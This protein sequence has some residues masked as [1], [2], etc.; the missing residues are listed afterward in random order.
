MKPWK[1]VQSEH[2]VFLLLSFGE[3]DWKLGKDLS[4]NEQSCRGPTPEEMLGLHHAPENASIAVRLYR[5]SHPGIFVAFKVK[6][7]IRFN[8]CI[9]KFCISCNDRIH[10]EIF[11][12]TILA[13]E[14]ETKNCR[15]AFSAIDSPRP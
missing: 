11:E 1:F 3:L 4:E 12:Y 10:T 14:Y 9:H 2:K 7:K 8:M 15:G 6:V 5:A 13:P